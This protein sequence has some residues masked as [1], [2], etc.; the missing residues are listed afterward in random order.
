MKGPYVPHILENQ[1][2]F[3]KCLVTFVPVLL[4]LGICALLWQTDQLH[5]VLLRVFEG[6][7]WRDLVALIV[8]AVLALLLGVWDY[9]LSTAFKDD[10][11]SEHAN[12]YLDKLLTQVILGKA[13]VVAA[14]PLIGLMA[15]LAAAWQR[16][17]ASPG[18]V[19]DA[20]AKDAA[21]RG[22]AEG[23]LKFPEVPR[24][25]AILGAA[26]A[27]TALVLFIIL[28]V[29]R[30]R[31]RLVNWLLG[32]NLLIGALAIIA[33]WFFPPPLSSLAGQLG[34]FTVTAL[35]SMGV[36]TVIY[37]ITELAKQR[38]SIVAPLLSLAFVLYVVFMPGVDGDLRQA[39]AAA[40]RSAPLPAPPKGDSELQ[41]VFADW[42]DKRKIGQG[43]RREPVFIF[44]L[45][46]GGIYAASA[47]ATLLATL[48]DRCPGFSR[49]V[50]AIS[51]VS[52]GA[53]GSAVFG[54]IL[55]ALPPPRETTC[56][57][58]APA[59]ASTHADLVR[60]VILADHLA[61]VGAF[62]LPD[63]L[64]KVPG[65]VNITLPRGFDRAEALE[66]SL[67]R[68]MADLQSNGAT[69]PAMAIA[70]RPFASH[71]S[72]ASHLPA[73]VLN[74]TW[75]ETGH[76][77]AFAP[78]PFKGVGDGTLL[79]FQ[80]DQFKSH[81]A[82]ASASLLK[83][84]VVSARFPGTSPAW[85]LSGLT[86]Q[87]RVRGMGLTRAETRTWNFVDGGYA[88]NSGTLTAY[89]IYSQLRAYI[90]TNKLQDR[91]DL[92]LVALSED[93]IDHL[94]D[95]TRYTDTVA[96]LSALLNVR[97]RGPIEVVSKL[98]AVD[99]TLRTNP[100]AHVTARSGRRSSL[101]V[102]RLDRDNFP[103]TLGW[104]ISEYRNSTIRLQLGRAEVCEAAASSVKQS[105][106]MQVPEAHVQA[107]DTIVGN[108]C[109]QREI[110]RLLGMR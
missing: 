65:L 6:R 11:Y 31:L 80:D 84:G 75:V 89:D 87:Q 57:R 20:L 51:A 3:F 44:A 88:D 55:A 7:L 85:Q 76:R 35:V 64:R 78:F 108:S 99:E 42:L 34:T 96:P 2:R 43:Q 103:Q 83:A 47:A 13:L 67:A 94:P 69:L 92:R 71:W 40:V 24:L 4:S 33:A 5:E 61:P 27:I 14:L 95:G 45:P 41:R 56:E 97:K 73:L 16:Q 46:G 58:L 38:I 86:V 19:V 49:H 17:S 79:S 70:T 37:A 12:P 8:F 72:V 68:A 98:A 90:E 53:V 21:L 100:E 32:A 54:S 93:D 39:N 18:S 23:T 25:L 110:F 82:V 48:Q 9:T 15:G 52:G 22:L 107:R 10:D 36:L 104:T 74:T 50:F 62:I 1:H 30:N 109:I 66:L 106:T 81:Q 77:V 28:A 63:L 59:T 26:L 29:H 101:L 102:F 91:I 60:E 105:P